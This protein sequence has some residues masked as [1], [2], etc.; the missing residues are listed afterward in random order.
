MIPNDIC[1]THRSVLAQPTSN[2]LP[3]PAEGDKRK[4]QWTDII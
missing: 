3:P 1:Y 2:K 4:D